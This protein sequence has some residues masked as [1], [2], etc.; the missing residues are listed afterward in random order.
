MTTVDA[1]SLPHYGDRWQTTLGWQ[2]N[3]GQ[4]QQFQQVHAQVLAA[5]RQ[6]NLTRITDP[7]DVWEKHFWD[8]LSAIAPWLTTESKSLR[9][10]DIGTGAG[11]PGIPVAIACPHWHVTLLDSTR[12]KLVFLDSLIESL[13]LNAT[14]LTGRAEAIGHHLAHREYYDLALVRA[15]GS[16]IA[17]A[18]YALPLVK[19]GGYAILYRGQWT[20]S[21]AQQLAQSTPFLGGAIDSVQSFHTPLSQSIRHCVI[22]KKIADTDP[23]LPRHIGIPAK[24]P[25]IES[26]SG[27]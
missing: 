6:F 3:D 27:S 16:A 21:E 7:D 22:L 2:P 5:N 20:D 11:F 12:K 23:E 17:C 26:K 25:L 9:V 13:S 15:V 24:I 8:S 19:L 4:Q 10:I 1:S 14:T 18:E